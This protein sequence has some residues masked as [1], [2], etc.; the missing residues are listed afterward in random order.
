[1]GRRDGMKR[2]FADIVRMAV[3]CC[4]LLLSA[5]PAFAAVGAQGHDL[6]QATPS[7]LAGDMVSAAG[8]AHPCERATTSNL[9]DCGCAQLCLVFGVL[10]AAMRIDDAG[11]TGVLSARPYRIVRAGLSPAK[12]PPRRPALV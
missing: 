12:H 2:G 3:L 6:Q 5:P 4:L 11:K 1:M 7:P 9:P 8:G 10:P